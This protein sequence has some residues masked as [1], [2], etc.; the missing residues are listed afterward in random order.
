MSIEVRLPDGAVARFPDGMPHEQIEAVLAQ[1]FGQQPE[2]QPAP[3]PQPQ[4]VASAEQPAPRQSFSVGSLFASPAA[5]STMPDAPPAAGQQIPTG[6]MPNRALVEELPPEGTDAY[7][8]E[9][10]RRGLQSLGQDPTR[11]PAAD[12]MRAIGAEGF[13]TPEVLQQYDALPPAQRGRILQE[14]QE[15]PFF[16]LERSIRELTAPGD[17][18][19]LRG[20]TRVAQAQTMNDARSRPPMP[21]E[22][23]KMMAPFDRGLESPEPTESGRPRRE[24]TGFS[25][26]GAIDG[27]QQADP[28]LSMS[29]GRTV[30]MQKVPKQNMDRG[31]QSGMEH[32]IAQSRGIID[33]LLRAG[34]TREAREFRDFIRDE[35]T[36]AG[37]EHFDRALIAA[38]YGDNRAFKRG[39]DGMVRAYEPNG[40]WMVDTSATKLIEGE[41]GTAIGAVLAL[42]N[43]ETGETNQIEVIGMDQVMEQLSA[44]GNPAAAF[45]R[46][47]EQGE[48]VRTTGDTQVDNQGRFFRVTQDGQTR[49]ITDSEG[50]QLF[51][52]GFGAEAQQRTQDQVEQEQAA[53]PQAPASQQPAR[54]REMPQA[55]NGMPMPQSQEDWESLP[56]GA[57]YVLPDGRIMVKQ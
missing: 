23:D 16:N 49:F 55:A 35:Q 40:P 51:A 57:Q 13:Y 2:A 1:H 37:M 29:D 38:K 9:R 48:P 25:A 15:N 36:I 52:R 20:D 44:W 4:Q 47:Q 21:S 39:L 7:Y 30:K 41:S 18:S 26:M 53:P 28:G 3:A 45:Q 24:R 5:A 8:L 56:S 10:S 46:R 11:A 17:G 31:V 22:R 42:K 32:L 33:S 19:M 12:V 43:Q 6:Q 34:K 27:P 54:P 14:M 50:N